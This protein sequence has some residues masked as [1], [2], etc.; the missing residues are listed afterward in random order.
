M[1]KF[2]KKYQD[3]LRILNQKEKRHFYFISSYG[4]V[5]G[6]IQIFAAFLVLPFMTYILNSDEFELSVFTLKITAEYVFIFGLGV[7]FFQVIASLSSLVLVY[8]NTQFTQDLSSRLSIAVLKEHLYANYS[9][10][11]S[12]LSGDY[13][14]KIVT[15]TKQLSENYYQSLIELINGLSLLVFFSMVLISM[16]VWSSLS[17]IVIIAILIF[18]VYYKIQLRLKSHGRQLFQTSKLRQQEL[19]EILH[20]VK[21]IKIFNAEA[22]FLNAF[23]QL[24][25]QTQKH[26]KSIAFLKEI[27]KNTIESSAIIA[28]LLFSLIVKQFSNNLGNFLPLISFYTLALYRL[29][30]SVYKVLGSL[31]NFSVYQPVFDYTSENLVKDPIIK[32]SE[33]LEFRKEIVFDQVSFK[34]ENRDQNVL[35]EFNLSIQKN[36]FI[37]IYGHSGKGKTTFF[38]LLLGLYTPNA[39]MI[40]LDHKEVKGL[41]LESY[42]NL[43]GYVS[44]DIY[45]FNMSVLENIAFAQEKKFINFERVYEVLKKVDLYDFV[46]NELKDNIYTQLG[47]KGISL[48]G[49]Q[50]QRIGIARVLYFNPEILIFDEAT[51]ALDSTNEKK[52]MDLIKDLAHSKTILMVSHHRDNL[53]DCQRIYE[54]RNGRMIE[55]QG[56]MHA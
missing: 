53:R 30:P 49:G 29:L 5:N 28:L 19:S 40:S 31:H 51:N 46:M 39:G 11:A 4:V 43:F 18:F 9:A 17:F 45:I 48:S 50:R 37:G 33:K 26:S 24:T 38:D 3:A 55:Q 35:S 42:H 27:P 41:N 10:I 16:N 14:K 34:Y 52:I 1:S 25:Q 7:I 12:R 54:L 20:N 36:E 13:I 2:L 22:F 56:E 21:L 44:Q 8:I 47:E 15:D 23:K 32:K 6:F